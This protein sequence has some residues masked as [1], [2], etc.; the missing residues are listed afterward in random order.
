MAL[1][2]LERLWESLSIK[3]K[4]A[5]G[6]YYFSPSKLPDILLH[7]GRCPRYN[8]MPGDGWAS[9]SLRAPQDPRPGAWPPAQPQRAALFV[10]SPSSWPGGAPC[11]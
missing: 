4:L 10:C 6:S 8:E 2:I 9:R 3:N 1:E 5:V 7:Y 11:S